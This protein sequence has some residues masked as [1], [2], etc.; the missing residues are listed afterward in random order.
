VTYSDIQLHTVTYSDIQLHT[1]TY[2]DIQLLH[3]VFV[4]VGATTYMS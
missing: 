3:T 2:S 4:T 1:V